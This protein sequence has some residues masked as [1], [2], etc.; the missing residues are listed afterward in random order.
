MLKAFHQMFPS[1][2]IIQYSVKLFPYFFWIRN[3]NKAES[4]EFPISQKKKLLAKLI[5]Q[6]ASNRLPQNSTW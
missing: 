6:Q 1:V 5:F 3:F 4:I 2:F